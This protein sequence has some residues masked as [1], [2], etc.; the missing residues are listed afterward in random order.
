M[1]EIH[2]RG[3]VKRQ[4]LT[5]ADAAAIKQLTFVC[6]SYE[7]LHTPLAL[8]VLRTRPGNQT[9]EFLY[10]EDGMLVGC[11]NIPHF[12]TREKELTGVVHP[13]YRRRGIFREL[14]NAAKEEC[15]DRG[16]HRLILVCE[17]ASTS[18]QVF[19]KAAGAPLNFS[20]YEMVLGTL[21]KRG[22]FAERLDLRK[23]GTADLDVLANILASSFNDEVEGA[24][25]SAAFVLDSPNRQFYL[26]SLAGEPIGC[27]NLDEG[28]AEIGIYAFGILPQYRRRGFGRQMLEEIISIIQAESQKGIMLDVETNNTNAIGLYLSCG[29]Q[30]RTTYDYY[31]LDISY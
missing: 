26:A 3:L 31:G 8:D 15:L 17:Q 10:Y 22:P 25:Q 11:L 1:P 30:I 29:F 24:K 2:K 28:D 20:E 7:G 27:L 21:Q 14:L 12:G 23:A 16:I 4:T 6:N 9:N 18:G 5:E 13:D 19:V